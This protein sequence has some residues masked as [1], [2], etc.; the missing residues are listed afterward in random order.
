MSGESDPL[1]VTARRVLL[2]ALS[3]LGVQRQALILIGAQAIYLH[4]GDGDLAVA[5]FTSDA[6]IA[7]DPSGLQDDPT[8]AT[9]LEVP[10]L[11][12]QQMLV[13][14]QNANWLRMFGPL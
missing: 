2:D 1:Y 9:A 14:G 8:L 10:G 11:K 13:C 3:A 6:D 7:I 4:T 12:G 5:P